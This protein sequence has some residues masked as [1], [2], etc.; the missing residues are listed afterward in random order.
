MLRQAV[1]AVLHRG[2]RGA[3]LR[4]DFVFRRQQVGRRL[5]SHFG[6]ASLCLPDCVRDVTG[7]LIGGGDV[8]SLTIKDLL[9]NSP[10]VSGAS[11]R[12][13]GDV[14]RVLLD[15]SK[16]VVQ[17]LLLLLVG[18]YSAVSSHLCSLCGILS[19]LRAV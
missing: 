6:V 18:C 17:L 5:R 9:S 3:D 1:E 11:V 2:V 13:V 14:L 7:R 15:V 16:L 4:F 19:S 12:S 10:G 8:A